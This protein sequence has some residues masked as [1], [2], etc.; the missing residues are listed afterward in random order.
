MKM[1]ISLLVFIQFNLLIAFP[2]YSETKR[3]I[4]LGTVENLPPFSFHEGGIL[5]GIDID[6]I[7]EVG[8]NL[9]LHIEIVTLPWARVIAELHNGAI[10]GAFSVYENE[11]RKK[12]CRY[13]DIIHYDNLGIVTRRSNEFKYSDIT[14]LYGKKI[15]KGVG[16]FINTDFENA[17][18]DKKIIV[19]EIND[20]TMSNIKK[21][22]LNRLDA[23]I[24]VVETM[25]F[26][27]DQ[28]G[29]GGEIVAI[30]EYIDANRP[31]Y[32]VFSRKSSVAQDENLI[33]KISTEITN[34]MTS[35]RYDKIKMKYMD[36]FN[37]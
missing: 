23:V 34:I 2:G 20:T 37:K 14:S 19:E 4:T 18:N 6:V 32:L 3:V 12:F 10:D 24:G 1:L 17:V 29:Y 16:V 27:S 31:G 26:Y 8:N 22:Y 33:E 28:L 36:Y 25:R 9:N 30:H 13:I 21:L 5:K 11:E 35:G 15:G 7:K